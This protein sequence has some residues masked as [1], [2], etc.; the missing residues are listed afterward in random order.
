MALM[1]LGASYEKNLKAT[2][3]VF[4][5]ALREGATG[6]NCRVSAWSI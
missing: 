6:C 5:A 1:M 2:L 4:V 3:I